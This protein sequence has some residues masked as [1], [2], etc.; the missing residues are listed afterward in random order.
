MSEDLRCVA[1][2]IDLDRYPLN[3]LDSPR[4]RALLTFCR[5]AL[6]FEG[7]CQLP[8]FLR[9]DAVTALVEEALAKREATWRTDDEHNVYFEPVSSDG[10]AR[11][12]LEH[13]SKSALAWDLVAADSP[14]RRAYMWD[15]LTA[16][17]GRALGMTPFFRYADALGAASLMIFDKGDELGWH[18][19]RSPFAQALTGAGFDATTHP[20]IGSREVLYGAMTD[21]S[22]DVV[23]EYN[24]ALLS[25]LDVDDTSA[26]TETVDAALAT[27]LPDQLAVLDPSPAQDRNTVVVRRQTATEHDLGSIAD[28]EPLAPGMSFG[29]APEDRTRYQGMVGLEQVYGLRFDSFKALDTAGPLTVDALSSGTV[30]A[31]ILYSTTPEI[32]ERGFVALSD[33]QNVFGVQ[34]VIP[35]I[36]SA[37]VPQ[38]ARTVLNS[39][40]AALDTTTLTELNA[41]VQIDQEDADVVAADWL[42]DHITS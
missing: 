11:A 39:V 24:G 38:A 14:L 26:T 42:A 18:F 41:R 25:Y 35:L 13:T 23:P 20:N 2:V 16:F 21:G 27:L 4:G 31:A 6:D 32:D 22:I 28:L 8:G 17:L 12:V 34:N 36:S 10:S 3:D 33:P 30:D 37:A 29:G 9:P 40:S 19:D 1:D 7:A 15:G 5:A